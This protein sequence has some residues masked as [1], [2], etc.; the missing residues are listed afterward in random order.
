MCEDRRA[1]M[2]D[3]RRDIDPTDESCEFFMLRLFQPARG[4]F[5]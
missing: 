5:G 3:Q 1:A 2:L 4:L